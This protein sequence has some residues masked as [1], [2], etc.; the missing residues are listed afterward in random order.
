MVK[1]I[2]SDETKQARSVVLCL[3]RVS[4][5]SHFT[6]QNILMQL[7]LCLCYGG[8]SIL[9][10]LQKCE[11]KEILLTERKTEQQNCIFC[12]CISNILSGNCLI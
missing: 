5:F 12:F 1:H 6:P 11:C 8:R 4:S 9:S 7:V 10:L 3:S 2:C